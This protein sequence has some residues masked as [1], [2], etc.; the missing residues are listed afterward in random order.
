VAD[1][2]VTDW[3]GT[4][5]VPGALVIYGAPVGRSIAM[6]EATVARDAYMDNI[7]GREEHP[8]PAPG[9]VKIGPEPWNSQ[10][11]TC[12]A[13]TE[14]GK[15]FYALWEAGEIQWPPPTPPTAS[16]PEGSS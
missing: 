1:Q 3:R 14:A 12:E 5:I 6:V 8:G 7:H 4:P 13:C 9:F 15:R 10:W 2:P 11:V 16:T